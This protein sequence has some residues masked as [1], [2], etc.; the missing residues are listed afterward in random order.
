MTISWVGMA[1]SRRIP[2][3]PRT[4][5]EIDD[6]S[7]LRVAEMPPTAKEQASPGNAGC[8]L[9]LKIENAALASA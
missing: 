9:K 2:R 8:G 6:G 5:G 3:R 4:E 7:R 1:P